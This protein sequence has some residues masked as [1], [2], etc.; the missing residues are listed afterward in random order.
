MIRKTAWRSP[1]GVSAIYVLSVSAMAE[2]LVRVTGLEPARLSAQEPNGSVTLLHYFSSVILLR[3]IA[4]VEA[5]WRSAEV[6]GGSTPRTPSPI[7]P[8][9]NPIIVR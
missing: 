9:L 2:D 7:R 1:D 5:L 4:S 6:A 8:P 3:P